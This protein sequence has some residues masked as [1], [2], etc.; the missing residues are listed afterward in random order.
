MTIRNALFSIEDLTVQRGP[1]CLVQ[2]LSLAL[3]PGEVLVLRG[4]N[5]TGKTSLLRVLAG[6]A[7]PLSGRITA[8]QSDLQ[9]DPATYANHIAY[10][11]HKDGFKGDFS[12]SANI[13][14]W[15]ALSSA[16]Y[17]P[18][19]LETVGLGEQADKP[20]RY[21]SAGQRRRLGLARL[22]SK[23]AQTWLLDEPFT[24]LD[25]AGQA[26]VLDRIK[27]HQAAGGCAIL[28]LHDPL[29]GIQHSRLILGDAAG[30]AA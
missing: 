21:L 29:E 30:A 12:V 8:A 19:I 15:C 3:A 11:G 26:L 27:A 17:Q 25:S 16:A 18:A 1:L 4:A 9:T 10:W 2:G 24:A 6:I 28:A 23:P 5:G 20:V 13:K 14:Q 22:L 7:R